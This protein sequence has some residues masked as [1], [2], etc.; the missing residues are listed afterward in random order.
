[1]GNIFFT[2]LAGHET[3]GG[4]LGFIFLLLAIYP[5]CQQRMQ[6]ELDDQLGGRR[7]D[8]WTLEK[9]YAALEQGYVG[10]IQKEVLYIFNPASFIMRKTLGLVTI[11]DSWASLTKSLRIHSRSSIMPLLPVTRA[12]GTSL[13]LRP[14]EVP[15]F[16]THQPCISTP[17]DGL[18]QLTSP[19]IQRP[20][21]KI[22]RLGR[23][24]V[25][26]AGHVPAR[27]LH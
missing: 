11:V 14:R 16:Q 4:T 12:I 18:D 25:P 6:K 3:T 22:S 2:L 7:M 1:M 20:T 23:H 21:T 24:S 8:E 5:E 13:K 27:G 17:T 26:E 9:D 15:R 19:T 10:A